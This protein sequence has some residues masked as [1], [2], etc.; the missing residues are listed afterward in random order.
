ME[1]KDVIKHIMDVKERLAS[2]EAINE[3]IRRD[4]KTHSD[5]SLRMRVE[6]DL[7]KAEVAEAKTVLNTIR[8][9]IGIAFLT[10]PAVA[11]TMLKIYNS[12]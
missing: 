10:M 5:A 6:V 1:D 9:V 3:E 12:F 7:V 2:I 8:W 4:L 11:A